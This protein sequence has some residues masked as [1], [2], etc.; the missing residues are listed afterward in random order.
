[1]TSASTRSSFAFSSFGVKVCLT[2]DDAELLKRFKSSLALIFK[3]NLKE[4]LPEEGD[5]IIEVWRG[6][7][8]SN[9]LYTF[10]GDTHEFKEEEPRLFRLLR[11]LVRVTVAGYSREKLFI[12]AGAV[13][14]KGRGL[15]IPAHSHS[16]KTSLV[17]ELCRLGA[18]YYSDEY[19]V[20][21]SA[22]VLFP[23]PK[24]LSVRGDGGRFDQRDEE[25]TELGGTVG[26]SP[27]QIRMVLFSQ[28]S[29]GQS[30]WNPVE[31]AAGEG[32]LKLVPHLIAMPIDPAFALRMGGSLT[33]GASAFEAPRGEA[34]IFAPKILEFLEKL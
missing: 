3:D 9:F 31:L 6:R 23:F 22:G 16:G 24:H 19:A 25:I 20:V 2:F 13:S 18:L 8:T 28:F 4:K 5:H 27:V 12:H 33:G 26:E 10:Q 11:T 14:W 15:I 1:M 21:D 30:L 34:G 29:E 32:L 17:I 7:S